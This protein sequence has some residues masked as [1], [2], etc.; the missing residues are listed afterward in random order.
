MHVAVWTT[1]LLLT[2]EPTSA[3]AAV[4]KAST[5]LILEATSLVLEV[6]TATTAKVVPAAVVEVIAAIVVHV[7]ATS[8]VSA[9]TAKRWSLLLRTA[10]VIAL[11]KVSPGQLAQPLR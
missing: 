7:T 10:I 8:K 11:T 4:V 5:A 9:A 1:A 6:T 2:I 3:A